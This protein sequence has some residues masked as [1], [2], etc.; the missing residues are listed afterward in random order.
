MQNAREVLIEHFRKID[1]HIDSVDG[2]RILQAILDAME[3]Y[4]SQRINDII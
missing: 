1:V 3:D 4:A 2:S